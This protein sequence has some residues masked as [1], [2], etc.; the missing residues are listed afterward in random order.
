MILHIIS[1]IANILYVMILNTDLYSDRAIMPNGEV[2]AWRRS[3]IFRL[4]ASGQ[5]VLLYLQLIFIAVSIITAILML[6]GAKNSALKR[7]WLISSIAAALLF[8]IIVVVTSNVH[9]KYA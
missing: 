7:I 9:A 3:P 4:N 2:R 6:F 5:S 8:V 1:I